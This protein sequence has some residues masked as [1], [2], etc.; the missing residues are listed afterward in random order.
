M[1]N[2]ARDRLF[3]HSIVIL[4]QETSYKI[5]NKVQEIDTK[6]TLYSWPKPTFHY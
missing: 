2:T 1:V 6:D 5:R 4:I 3:H